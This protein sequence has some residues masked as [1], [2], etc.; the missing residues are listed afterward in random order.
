MT[1]Q[2][3]ADSFGHRLTM[4]REAQGIAQ[5]ALYQRMKDNGAKISAASIPRYELGDMIPSVSRIIEFA[6]ALKIPVEDL[7]GGVPKQELDVYFP[8]SKGAIQDK[9]M[10]GDWHDKTIYEIAMKLNVSA[11]AVSTSVYHLKKYHGIQIDYKPGKPQNMTG[12]PPCNKGTTPWELTHR[13]WSKLTEA[14]IAAALNKPE[15][16]VHNSIGYLRRKYGYTVKCMA[17]D[18]SNTGRVYVCGEC[19]K[20]DYFRSS[21]EYSY[22][23][24]NYQH[25]NLGREKHGPIAPKVGGCNKFKPRTRGVQEE[26]V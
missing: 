22:C 3:P 4:A 19:R 7:T 6:S 1:K 10:N 2:N 25:F 13:N 18:G 16:S 14:G 5:Y 21:G 15:K 23:D 24:Y 8:Q 26:V 12:I 11:K 20:C 9:L 17:Y